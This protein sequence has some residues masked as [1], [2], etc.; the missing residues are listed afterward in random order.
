M[1]KKAGAAR[2][3]L[4][5][6]RAKQADA[7]RRKERL[8]RVGIAVGVVVVLVAIAALVQW[9]RSQVDSSAAFPAGASALGA[10]VAVG[11]PDAPV[12]VEA[13]EDFACPHCKEFEDAAE[14]ALNTYVSE[15]KV[16][17]VYFPVTLPGFGRPTELAA[18]AFACAADAGK[19]QEYHDALYA[20][21]R[22]DWTNQ[23]LVELGKTVG[24]TSGTFSTCVNQDSFN[25]WVKSIDQTGS[26][27][28]VQ[29][30]PTIFVNGQQIPEGDTSLDGLRTAVNNALE[31]KS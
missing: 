19:G 9:Q 1:S 8:M 31:Q 11:K 21:F 17:V 27:R 25:D 12:L 14:S 15:G 23:Q 28:G 13:F 26:T 4:E 3:A 6:Q 22:Q 18:N 30:T 10:G 29:G 5:A 16:R 24:L 7:E 2:A 20:N